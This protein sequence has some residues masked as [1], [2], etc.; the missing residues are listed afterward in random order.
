MNNSD[1]N[2][3]DDSSKIRDELHA[4]TLEQLERKISLIGCH[5]GDKLRAL[6]LARQLK[7]NA[8]FEWTQENIE[9]LLALDRRMIEC[10]EKLRDEAKPLLA[11]F[12]KRIETKD[13]FLQ[14][15]E[16]DAKVTPF[17][18]EANE[19]GE[20]EVLDTGVERVLSE[21]LPENELTIRCRTWTLEDNIYFNDELNW[22]SDPVFEGKLNGHYI[23]F[24]I[25]V[26]HERALWS[27]PD[28]LKINYLRAELIV[29][30]Q[31]FV[32]TTALGS[33]EEKKQQCP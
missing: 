16:M 5:S 30:R 8:S 15:F 31:H 2:K 27:F 18:L 13:A 9:K 6:L 32:K 11:E 1:N 7:L 10:F 26:L 3:P 17:I 29:R 28:I 21:F 23:S 19:N 25:H 33:A 22:N 12:Q 24:A 20:L 4:C 14:D